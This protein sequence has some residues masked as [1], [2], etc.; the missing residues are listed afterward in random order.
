MHTLP[1]H[2]PDTAARSLSIGAG[3]SSPT[4]EP[5][6]LRERRKGHRTKMQKAKFWTGKTWNACCIS[7]TLAM[8]AVGVAKAAGWL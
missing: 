4:Q 1:S 5:V 2:S 7:F 6:F 8:C 3:K